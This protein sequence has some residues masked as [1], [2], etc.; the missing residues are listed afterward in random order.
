MSDLHLYPLNDAIEHD[1]DSRECVCGVEVMGDVVFHR[2]LNLGGIV[3]GV[4]GAG[5]PDEPSGD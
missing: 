4:T 3:T 5:D 1:T 2:N